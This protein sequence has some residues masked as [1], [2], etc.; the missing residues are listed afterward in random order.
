MAEIREY[1]AQIVE[2]TKNFEFDEIFPDVDPLGDCPLCGRPVYERSWFY[3]CKEQPEGQEDCPFRI[4]K[5]KS[6][7][8]IDRETAATLLCDGTT[9]EL[10]GF[11]RPPWPNLQGDLGP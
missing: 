10:D 9:G 4:W 1:T 2:A 6:G 7:R 3:R 5:D 11:S 8:Y